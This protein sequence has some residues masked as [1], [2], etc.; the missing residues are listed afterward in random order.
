MIL[1]FAAGCGSVCLLPDRLN[2]EE[3]FRAVLGMTDISARPNVPADLLSF[4]IPWPMYLE[5]EGN[6][7]GSFLDRKDW[8][9]VKARLPG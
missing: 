9:K 7:R 2:L 5:M 1:R 8:L 6:V 4:T 3:P